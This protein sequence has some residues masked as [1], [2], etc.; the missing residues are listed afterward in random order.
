MI[1][2]RADSFRYLKLTPGSGATALGSVLATDASFIKL[3]HHPFMPCLTEIGAEH[4][5][6]AHLTL[7]TRTCFACIL[8]ELAT[9]SFRRLQD[10]RE[11]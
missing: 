1:M 3:I 11:R 5:M 10:K 6:R 9:H 7:R 2:T 4:M 8:T